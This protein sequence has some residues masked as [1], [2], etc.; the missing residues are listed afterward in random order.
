MDT[1]PTTDATRSPEEFL[2]LIEQVEPGW[3]DEYGG[4]EGVAALCAELQTELVR[5]SE[6][7]AAIR[8][9]AIR[10]M[11]TT[12]SGV[13]VAAELGISKS[14]VSKS[15]KNTPWKDATW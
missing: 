15:L 8:V 12:K 14:A 3:S 1:P 7:I 9:A 4:P 2:A 11:L 5:Q 10:Q 6:K 13:E